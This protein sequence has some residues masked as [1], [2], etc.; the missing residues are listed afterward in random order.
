MYAVQTSLETSPTG[1]ENFQDSYN[2]VDYTNDLDESMNTQ[3]ILDQTDY[4]INQSNENIYH[5]HNLY[6]STLN[7]KLLNISIQKENTFDENEDGYNQF[8]ERINTSL[9]ESELLQN[10]NTTSINLSKKNLTNLNQLQYENNINGNQNYLTKSQRLE[11]KNERQKLKLYNEMEREFKENEIKL[12]KLRD[13]YDSFLQ[14]RDSLQALYQS[15]FQQFNELSLLPQKRKESLE[16]LEK[17]KEII[18]SK[19]QQIN[20]TF[21]NLNDFQ[22]EQ[23]LLNHNINDLKPTINEFQNIKKD[24]FQKNFSNAQGLLI[25]Q[26]LREKQKEKFKQKK[27][28][29]IKNIE[30]NNEKLVLKIIENAKQE[31][32]KALDFLKVT[33]QRVNTEKKIKKSNEIKESLRKEKALEQLEQNRKI[34]VDRIKEQNEKLKLKKKEKLEKEANEIKTIAAEGGNP[35][36]VLRS[37]KMQKLFEK[38]TRDLQKK[39]YE[40]QIAVEKKILIENEKFT[41]NNQ[42]DLK[43][44]EHIELWK[45]SISKNTQDKKIASYI[46]SKTTNGADVIDPLGKERTIYPSKVILAKDW[47]FGLGNASISNPLALE[48]MIEKHSKAKVHESLIPKETMWPPGFPSTVQAMNK[49]DSKLVGKNTHS[50]GLKKKQLKDDGEDS[51]EDLADPQFKGLWQQKQIISDNYIDDSKLKVRNLTSLEKQYLEKKRKLQKESIIKKQVCWGK[52]FEGQGFIPEPKEIIFKDFELGETYTQKI[53]LTNASLTFNYFKLLSLE[54]EIKNFFDIDYSPPGKMSA[55]TSSFFT[56]TFNPRILKD[57]DSFIPV[58]SQTGQFSIPLKCM[59]KKVV[60]SV[61]SDYEVDRL[62]RSLFKS[63]SF[64]NV[65]L[66]N[67]EITTIKNNNINS[68]NLSFGSVMIAESKEISIQIKNDGALDTAVVLNGPAILEHSL[69][70]DQVNPNLPDRVLQFSSKQL[71]IKKFSTTTLKITFFPQIVNQLSSEVVLHFEDEFTDDITFNLLGEGTDVSIFLAEE[72]LKFNYAFIDT[73]YRETLLV[74]NRGKIAMKCD[75]PVPKELKSHLEFVPNIAYIQ[76]NEPFAIQVKFRPL[77]SILTDCSSFI[78]NGTDST[79]SIPLPLSIP[80]QT[81]IVKANLTATIT[82]SKLEISPPLLNFGLVSLDEAISIPITIKN[83]S[84]LPQEFGF[85]KYPSEISISPNDGFASIL[86]GESLKFD[87]V[88]T[89]TSAIEYHTKCVVRTVRNEDFVIPIKAVGVQPPVKLTKPLIKTKA[90]AI[91]DQI[92]ETIQIVN[93]SNQ[94]HT[95][96]FELTEEMKSSGLSILPTL[97]TLEPKQELSVVLKFIP[98]TE[99]TYPVVKPKLVEPSPIINKNAKNSKKELIP[100]IEESVEPP[101]PI[102]NYM[103]WDKSNPDEIWSR[104]KFWLIPCYIPDSESQIITLGVETTVIKPSLISEDEEGKPLSVLDFGQIA[105]Q[106]PILKSIYIRNSSSKFCRVDYQPIEYGAFKLV[107]PP[108]PLQPNERCEVTI[109]FSPT[110]PIQFSHEFLLLSNE[111]NNQCIT[112]KGSGEIPSFEVFPSDSHLDLGDALEKE[113]DCKKTLTLKNNCTIPLS[114]NIVF[115]MKEMQT[116]NYDGSYPFSSKPSSGIIQP[117]ASTPITISFLPDHPSA[118]YRAQCQIICGADYQTK[119]LTLAGRAWKQGSY[120][121]FLNGG[122]SQSPRITSSDSSIDLLLSTKGIESFQF[123]QFED[124]FSD[125]LDL[126]IKDNSSAISNSN[127]KNANQATIPASIENYNHVF[128]NVVVGEKHEFIFKV[129]NTKS[130]SKSKVDI[131]FEGFSA[132]DQK[133]GFTIDPQKFSLDSGTTK[134]V[135]ITFSPSKDILNL[136]PVSDVDIWVELKL[137]ANVKQATSEIRQYNFSFRGH[138]DTNRSTEALK[139]L[140]LPQAPQTKKK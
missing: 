48:Q 38:N 136:V 126:N 66:S 140:N 69:L 10:G 108:H 8:L 109:E 103:N 41:K 31:R 2:S 14:E 54:D 29:E 32:V 43:R 59:T 92:S 74:C 6:Q 98:P 72:N 106:R 11:K 88:F 37:R 90:T 118:L 65:A 125:L 49:F 47:S 95:F 121:V 55:G 70:Y 23:T 15:K 100:E 86:P 19:E 130:A 13:Q 107:K 97:A 50:R 117:G 116:I 78:D 35:Y 5:S 128:K 46:Q 42:Q 114:Y 1:Q 68:R 137:I 73:L 51:D 132:T 24:S 7:Q 135:K 99:F 134:D 124:P 111:L 77:S 18:E 119:L 115:P 52:V 25:K 139:A 20:T 79:I 127:P 81:M 45:E 112:L 56:I 93:T 64:G 85:L 113:S 40:S 83:L 30:E 27:L 16:E 131:N 102:D 57:I 133:N 101:S 63:N 75:F 96:R 39:M 76:P 110:K 61:K 58:L 3:E 28:E 36:E 123:N 89:P 82:S 26:D 34:A 12:N 4:S 33:Q 17:I 105:L 67:T 91:G 138:V 21:K 94:N 62:G 129:G 104:H 9:N 80:N 122:I 87:I 84:L 71:L 44:R 60:V 22:S 120:I 53:K